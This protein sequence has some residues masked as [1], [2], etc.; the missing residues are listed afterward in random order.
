MHHRLTKRRSKNGTGLHTLTCRTLKLS[1]VDRC[2]YIAPFENWLIFK[3]YYEWRHTDDFKNR[4]SHYIQAV[5]S[6]DLNHPRHRSNCP[7]SRNGYA[8][9][10]IPIQFRLGH[11]A[12]DFSEK[13]HIVTVINSKLEK[14][15][16][17]P[18][19]MTNGFLQEKTAALVWRLEPYPDVAVMILSSRFFR[20]ILVFWLA[21]LKQSQFGGA[22]LYK[23]A[24]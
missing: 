21:F 18:V 12:L 10:R 14:V 20:T 16:E 23:S 17:D 15:P 4:S 1:S 6:V 7:N 8:S 3:M 9:I 24:L 13:W 11:P 22:Q 5:K 19:V 2:V